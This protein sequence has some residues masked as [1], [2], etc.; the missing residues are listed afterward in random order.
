MEWERESGLFPLGDFA[1][2]KGGVI[3]GAVLGWERHGTM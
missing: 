3:R 1:A 2:E